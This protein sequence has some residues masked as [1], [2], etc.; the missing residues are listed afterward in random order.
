[1][2]RVTNQPAVARPTHPEPASHSLRTLLLAV[3]VA[4][5][6]LL[7]V[8]WALGD[9]GWVT[10]Q[11]T[12]LFGSLAL[13]LLLAL[14]PSLM[15]APLA[16]LLTALA[17]ITTVFVRLSFFGLVQF[18]GAGFTDDVFIHLEWKSIE[19][20]WE[21]YRILC[22]ALLAVLACV[23]M[24]ARALVRRLPRL[25]RGKAWMLMLAALVA[26]TA[27]RTAL[28]EGMLAAAT[29][30]WYQP[31]RLDLPDSELQRWRDSGLVEV[32]LPKKSTV[33]ASA[34]AS[35]RN[36]ILIYLESLG[37][38]VIEHPD[39]PGLMPNLARRMKA[40]SLLR[41]YFAAGFIT[42][43][44]IT[45]SQCGTLFPFE[46]ESNSLAGFDGMAEEQA[47]LGDVLA[48]AGYVQSYLG[49]A[50]ASFA[51]KGRFLSLHGYDRVL[52]LDE[53]QAMGLE[54]RPDNWG[55]ADP[56]LFDQAL[57]ELE[58][59]SAEGKPFS[60]TLLTIGSHLPGFT[61]EEC[62]P[63]GSD[64]AFIEALHC[65]DQLL[66]D[67]LIRAEAAGHLENSV[68]VLTADHHVF[69]SPRMKRLFGADAVNDR[70]LPLLVL[71]KDL[72]SSSVASGASYDLAPTVLDLLDVQTDVRFALGRSLL[73]PESS[74]DY[75]PTRF[76]DFHHGEVA[77]LKDA[78]CDTSIPAPP[79]TV[80]EKNSL[81]TL[82]RVQNAG[83]SIQTST[84]LDCAVD[85]GIRIH[86]P[87]GQDEAIRF[88][89]SGEDHASR[90]TWKARAS[91]EN[92][93]G[94][95]IAAFSP[96]GELL[97]RIFMHA[98]EA[99][100]LKAPPTIDGASQHLF[101]W[102]SESGPPA[103]LAKQ[104]VTSLAVAMDN[105]GGWHHLPLLA[106]NEATQ[107]VLPSKACTLWQDGVISSELLDQHLNAAVE[108]ATRLDP[109]S[110]FCPV[111]QWGP[112]EVFAGERFNP[113]PDGS[114]AFWLKTDCA[115]PRAMLRF[116][117]HLL[118]TMRD[119]SVLTAQLDADP[120]LRQEGEW[121]LELYDPDTRQHLPIGTLRVLPA[122]AP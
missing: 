66:E 92:K 21:H 23:P 37:Q 53:W 33:R 112:L 116:D 41:D 121:P 85:D 118:E 11:A 58:R 62:R 14:L 38:R 90:F 87:A 50:E 57:I 18:S 6:L 93:P 84:Q 12:H 45:N 120:Y 51:G 47:C 19:V 17:L 42:I 71:G 104:A 113:Q 48:R 24:A 117:G 63:Y 94:L 56:D 69:P 32:D 98:H 70:R 25:T 1:M 10:L 88:F 31:K 44:G 96:Q 9:L 46:R 59:L 61:Y 43:E 114:S 89:I 29:H 27:T 64:E 110:T 16:A 67:F 95:F 2:F 86:V 77:R 54:A 34:P 74:R 97:D 99:V 20:A 109:D 7:P 75:Y 35:P 72:P 83:Y 107:F 65:S 119:V 81:L 108:G 111:L 100:A 26:I 15:P 122:R 36:L 39:Y 73:R 40:D 80:C 13:L 103:W 68:V 52:G 76:I 105:L 28:P 60:L 55:L 22:L 82:L 78:G 5:P 4:A 79:L 30:A 3:L 115:P 106:T 101:V 102:R 91:Q 49:G 8:H